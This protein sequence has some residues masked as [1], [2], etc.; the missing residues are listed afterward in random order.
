MKIV[1]VK[2]GTKT[3]KPQGFCIGYVDEGGL[4]RSQQ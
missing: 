3:A 1:V 2:K 4:T